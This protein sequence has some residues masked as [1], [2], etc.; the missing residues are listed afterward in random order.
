MAETR[1]IVVTGASSGIGRALALQAAR[2]GFAVTLVAR[3]ADRL[4]SIAT[5]IRE[6]GGACASIALDVCGDGAAERIVEA[7]AGAFGRIDVVVN[8]AG[9]G[10]LGK[11]LEIGDAEIGA[12]LLLHVLAPI[13]IARA[14]LPYLKMTRGQLIFVGSGIARVPVPNYGAYALAKGAIRTASTQLRREL[15]EDGIAVTYLDPGLV[16]TEFHEAIG[17]ERSKEVPPAPPERVAASILRS[18]ERRASTAH[19]TPWQTFGTMIGEWAATLADPTVIAMAP[20]TPAPT[21]RAEPVE[22]QPPQTGASFD[23]LRTT[24]D[25]LGTTDEKLGTTDGLGSALEP[26]ARRMERVKLPA[27]FVASVLVRDAALELNEVAMRWAGMPNKNERAALHEVFDVLTAAGYLQK[28]G[29][30]S[31]KV[32]RAAD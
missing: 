30:E 13:R 23:K 20:K 8:N 1:N 2:D 25:K 27:S 32:L 15:R 9:T 19:G 22:A 28:T 18:I 26:L 17:I 7:A 31:W 4:T 6:S 5:E 29:E 10:S 14:A 12:Q 3:R 21:C 16:A 11:L 24:H